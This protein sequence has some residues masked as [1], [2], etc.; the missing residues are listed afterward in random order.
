MSLTTPPR[1]PGASAA[2]GAGVSAVAPRKPDAGKAEDLRS[3]PKK[4]MDDVRRDFKEFLSVQP[5]LTDLNRFR[6]GLQSD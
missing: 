4:T 1:K 3:A 5:A 2:A 6:K